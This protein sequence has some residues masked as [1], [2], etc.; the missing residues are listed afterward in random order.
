MK[1][2][3]CLKICDSWTRWFLLLC[4]W[5]LPNYF[6]YSE[7]WCWRTG[8]SSPGH[9]RL[10]ETAGEGWC[11]MGPDIKWDLVPLPLVSLQEMVLITWW[12]IRQ[13][14]TFL[15]LFVA[16]APLYRQGCR[17]TQKPERRSQQKHN[18]VPWQMGCHAGMAPSLPGASLVF[19]M[20]I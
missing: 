13:R 12:H 14:E 11:W 20:A 5:N 7:C 4:P 19:P 10:K 2:I 3:S 8:F 1:P 17:G 9:H 15:M 18:F 16:A 6:V